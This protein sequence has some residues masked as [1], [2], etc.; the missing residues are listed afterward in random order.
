MLL[1]S[2]LQLQERD[3]QARSSVAAH[4]LREL[5]AGT[6]LSFEDF[7]CESFTALPDPLWFHR[8]AHTDLTALGS[9]READ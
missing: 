9:L 1:V 7:G 4:L 5:D 3:A 8:Q 2:R 6:H